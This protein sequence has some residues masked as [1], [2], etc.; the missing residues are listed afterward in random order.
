M[1]LQVRSRSEI[2]SLGSATLV[3]CVHAVAGVPYNVI[4]LAFSGVPDVVSLH[5]FAGVN[6]V[7]SDHTVV[8]DIISGVPE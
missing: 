6:A 1:T 2:N 8:P 4:V 7:V 5:A 3:I